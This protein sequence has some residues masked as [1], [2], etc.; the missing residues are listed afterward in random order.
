MVDGTI[1]D[2]VS[3]YGVENILTRN[4]LIVDD[5]APNLDVLEA[6]LGMDYLVS[7]AVSGE[8]ALEI[9]SKKH[10]DVIITDQRMPGM[11]GVDLLERVKLNYRDVAGIVLTGYSD[12]SAI[13][14]AI[15]RASVFWFLT[16]PWDSDELMTVVGQAMDHVFQRRSIV[17]L[18]DILDVRNEELTHALS[19]IHSAQQ[20]MLHMER[21]GTMGR[22]TAGVTHDLRNFLVGLTFLEED[23]EN[24]K[25]EDELKE[26]LQ[27]GI[28]GVRNLMSTLET[29]NQFARSEDVG[30]KKKPLKPADVIRDVV[31]VLRMD[32][33]FRRRDVHTDVAADV[34]NVVADR[35]KLTQVMVNLVR[36]AVQATQ[37]GQRVL[38]AVEKTEEGGVRFVVEDDGTGI[39][40]ELQ[41]SMFDPFVSSKG[42]GGM[43]MGLYMARLVL[44]SHGGSIRYLTG[45]SGGARFEA[46]LPPT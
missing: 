46:S 9:I 20:K 34:P 24:H 1:Q 43:G 13:M 33:E 18:V 22:L 25:V 36:N 32:M 19:E 3:K 8:S 28:A 31:T 41:S 44:N 30:I 39:P 16:K 15:N 14:D 35:R 5:E 26:S 37:P 38:M 6:V 21:L 12:S 40:D 11:T 27:V 10:I 4:I 23:F 17:R 29:M 42:D 2:L 45:K 7:T